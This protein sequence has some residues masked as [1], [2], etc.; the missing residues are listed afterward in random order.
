MQDKHMAAKR[1]EA[2]Q[3]HKAA[4]GAETGQHNGGPP[5]LI[6]PQP[7]AHTDFANLKAAWARG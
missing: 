5:A 7:K 2:L 3:E 6:P 1:E 4:A